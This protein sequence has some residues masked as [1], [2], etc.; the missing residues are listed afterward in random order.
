MRF[1]ET[2]YFYRGVLQAA[3][4]PD[5]PQWVKIQNGSPMGPMSSEACRAVSIST[6]PAQAVGAAQPISCIDVKFFK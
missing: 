4:I 2:K 3:N 1:L 6:A 5:K